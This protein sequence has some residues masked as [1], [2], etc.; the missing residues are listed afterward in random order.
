MDQQQIPPQNS[1][2]SHLSVTGSTF[3][4]WIEQEEVMR[5]LNISENT[6]RKYIREGLLHHTPLI[7]RKLFYK[8]HILRGLESRY[9]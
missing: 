1:Q 7:K 8:P 9:R 3:E 6:V 5:L 2:P 4:D